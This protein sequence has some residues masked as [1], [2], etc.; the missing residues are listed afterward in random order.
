MRFR[1]V[2]KLHNQWIKKKERE[3]YLKIYKKEGQDLLLLK[4]IRKLK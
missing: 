1:K 3:E 4:E 2:S